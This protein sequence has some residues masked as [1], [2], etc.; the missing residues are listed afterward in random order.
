MK[1]KC[2]EV[3]FLRS[4]MEIFIHCR[5]LHEVG[6]DVNSPKAS[7]DGPCRHSYTHEVVLTV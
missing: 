7:I 6:L 2:W 5:L 1:L 4:E 3:A